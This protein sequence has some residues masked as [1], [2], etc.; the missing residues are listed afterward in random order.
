M[1]CFLGKKFSRVFQTSNSCTLKDAIYFPVLKKCRVF[2]VISRH[3]R[4]IQPK[5]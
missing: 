3:V 2:S 4:N 5:N 1:S